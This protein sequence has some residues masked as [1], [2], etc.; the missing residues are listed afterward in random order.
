[1]ADESG[2]TIQIPCQP[3]S[4]TWPTSNWKANEIVREFYVLPLSSDTP[5]GRYDLTLSLAENDQRIGET[6]VLGTVTIEPYTPEIKTD[7]RWQENI[8]LPGYSIQKNDNTLDVSLY[9]QATAP[10]TQSLTV[11]AHIIGQASE[12]PAAQSDSIPRNW[13]YPTFAWEPGEI[14]Q[15]NISI[16]LDL[17]PGQYEVWLGLSGATGA[18]V[19]VEFSDL[20]HTE[21]SVQIMTFEVP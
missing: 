20:P 11:F 21:N 15:D 3:L 2:S 19:P 17:P 7:T 1:L 8:K 12:Q 18:R 16:P 4:K 13:R 14:V 9:W 5:P 10:I 6:A